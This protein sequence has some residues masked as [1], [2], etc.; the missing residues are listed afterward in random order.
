MA[1]FPKIYAYAVAM[2]RLP[3]SVRS[4]V[5]PPGF[6]LQG[7]LILLPAL[8]LAGV[9]LYSL[10]QDR[11]LA[12]HEARAKARHIAVDMADRFV[13]QLAALDLAV[14]PATGMRF[15]STKDNPIERL[16]RSGWVR[17][18]FAL[19]LDGRLLFPPS[20]A[21]IPRPAPLDVAELPSA[22][23]DTWLALEGL[24]AGSGPN[25]EEAERL[26][27]EFVAAQPPERFSAIAR[28]RMALLARSAGQLA[29]C[30]ELLQ[31]LVGM[32]SEISCETGIPLHL[33]AEWLLAETSSERVKEEI[34]D[35]LCGREVLEGS[36]LSEA[37]VE[38]A[39]RVNPGAAKWMD[40]LRSHQ[41]ARRFYAAAASAM[42]PG[43][44]HLKDE[45]WLAFAQP[46]EGGTWVLGVPLSAAKAWYTELQQGS[47][48]SALF[49]SRVT[50]GGRTLLGE[51]ASE[52]ALATVSRSLPGLNG[53]LTLRV[54]TW[55]ADAKAFYA[56]QRTRSLRFGLLIA[57]SAVAVFIG[58]FTAWRAFR[59]QRQLSE[60]KTNFVSSVSHE[61]R[62]PIA[63][64]RLMAE[65]LAEGE[66][67]SDEKQKQYHRFIGQECRRLS[68]V[69][70]NVLDF[71]RREQGREQ[72]DFE[73]TDLNALVG[74]T[75]EL[76]RAYAGEKDIRLEVVQSDQP[77]IVEAD[78]R[79]LHRLLVNLID[80]A[81]KHAPANGVVRIGSEVDTAA[82][83]LWVEDNG[84]GIPA[85]EHELIFE[86]FYRIG[87][88]LRRETQG[89][90]LGLSIV[91]HIAEVHNGRVK[92]FSVVGKGSRFVI[93]LPLQS[94]ESRP[95]NGSVR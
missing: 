12:E 75:V 5:R 7:T 28:L 19:G 53:D 35:R 69:I 26:F 83:R 70:E 42:E 15:S 79:A 73:P 60:M 9:S 39:S 47:A 25:Y 4:R 30:R 81:I 92:V 48:D 50:I 40:V 54:E 62:A 64:V 49:R 32:A 36:S 8:L 45:E 22:Q 90:G 11:V 67:P 21:P 6:M 89:V 85:A 91:K 46:V 3:S 23:Q 38:R 18:G 86:R 61:L 31:P 68:A 1:H 34:M 55:L 43:F 78:G 41:E 52:E 95:L 63:S 88:E 77:V 80:N 2:R 93:E 74:E 16:R 13:T 27:S 72:F 24:F 10:R 87:N 71:S 29:R 14:I 44:V 76:M 17:T 37:L 57:A 59:R 20:L 84:P 56:Q 58:F 33:A 82:T 65:E 94:A 66:N 51:S